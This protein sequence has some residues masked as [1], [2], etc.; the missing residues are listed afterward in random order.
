MQYSIADF[1]LDIAQNSLEADAS[2]VTI[3]YIEDE[4]MITVMIGDNGK[5]MDEETLAKVKDPFFTD[6]VKHEKR[7]VGLG[8]PFLIQATE[9]AG[10]EFDIVSNTE[11]GTSV[12]F[13]FDKSNID[14]PIAG[15]LPSLFRS[16]MIYEGNYDLLIHRVYV[17]R[18]WRVTRSE[19]IEALGDLSS[20]DSLNLALDYFESQEED[21][22][23][24][25]VVHVK[26]YT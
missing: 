7:K 2:L 14:C 26:A 12:T 4:R 8:I 11:D 25:E 6:G 10:G 5:G 13:S 15:N 20:A 3:D 18:S 1:V 22:H 21:I 16:L 17:D 9:S 19:L 24:K 23:R